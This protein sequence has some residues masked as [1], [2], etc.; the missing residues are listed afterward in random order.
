M[1]AAQALL[2]TSQPKTEHVGEAHAALAIDIAGE[3]WL[4]EEEE[5]LTRKW[6]TRSRT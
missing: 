2:A 5:S 6:L 4:T 3:F 1:P